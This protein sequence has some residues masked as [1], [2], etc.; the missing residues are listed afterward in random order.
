[1]LTSRASTVCILWLPK[2][3][4]YFLSKIQVSLHEFSTL[5]GINCYI[6]CY[7][8]RLGIM[9][10]TSG[11]RISRHNTSW[12]LTVRRT[13]TTKISN[14]WCSRQYWEI[15]WR[16]KNCERIEFVEYESEKKVLQCEV[17]LFCIEALGIFSLHLWSSFRLISRCLTP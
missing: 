9:N 8:S 15:K 12:F 3:R 1:M 4:I 5:R 13:F 6:L 16:T 2:P 17:E 10:N 14:S 11:V 7:S